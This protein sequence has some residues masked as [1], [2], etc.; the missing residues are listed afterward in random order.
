MGVALHGDDQYARFQCEKCKKKF[1]ERGSYLSHKQNAHRP[2]DPIVA[3][4]KNG[5]CPYDNCDKR[6][7]SKNPAES[8]K[9]HLVHTHKDRRFA[10]YECKECGKLFYEKTRYKEH[11]V[12]H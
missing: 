2:I 11:K 8:V 3:K 9:Y 12:K 6:Y 10:K 7:Y 5:E 4:I 1:Y